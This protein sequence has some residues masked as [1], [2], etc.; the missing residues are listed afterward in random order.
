MHWPHTKVGMPRL[1]S[2][3]FRR[4]VVWYYSKLPPTFQGSRIKAPRKH[5]GVVT[6]GVRVRVW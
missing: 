3:P 6:L 1:V 2:V 4:D 5:K